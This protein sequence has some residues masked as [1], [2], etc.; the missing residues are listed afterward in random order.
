MEE[1]VRV[2]VTEPRKR[3]CRVVFGD[4]VVFEEAP[5]QSIFDSILSPA[6]VFC[7]FTRFEY[8][9]PMGKI[10]PGSARAKHLKQSYF[11]SPVSFLLN[12][13]LIFFGS[14]HPEQRPETCPGYTSGK[15]FRKVSHP[16]KSI[17]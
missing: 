4:A 9:Y 16:F 11:V 12:H 10:L 6:N 7:C 5:D 17:Q 8:L 2:V 14:M 15:C 13:I 3:T 1:N